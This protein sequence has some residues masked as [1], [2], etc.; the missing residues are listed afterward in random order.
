MEALIV[1]VPIFFVFLLILAIIYFAIKFEKKLIARVHDQYILFAEKFKLDCQGPTK[2]FFS[3]NYPRVNGLLGNFQFQLY[4][5]KTGGKNKVT[6]TVVEIIAPQH[7]NKS[8]RIL[9]EGFLGSIGKALGMQD[10][11]IGHTAVDKLYLL[12]SNDE[13]WLQEILSDPAILMLLEELHPSIKSVIGYH[14]GVIKYQEIGNID[15]DISRERV[16][17]ITALIYKIAQAIT[18][19]PA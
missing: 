12:K 16:E 3:T 19:K 1:V 5:Y 17:K 14:N 10:I 15:Q 11:Q 7:K 4:S 9:K 13:A 18:E 2:S 8:F 6:Y